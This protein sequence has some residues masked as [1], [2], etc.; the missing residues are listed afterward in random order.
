[1]MNSKEIRAEE[2]KLLAALRTD[3]PRLE[4]LWRSV[5][6]HWGGEDFVYRFYHQSFKVFALQQLTNSIVEALRSL[7]PHLP[8]NPWFTEIVAEGTGKTFTY[9]MNDRWT[10]EARPIVEAFF[11]ARYFL[12]MVCKYGKE[13]Q[14]RRIAAQR[15]GGGIGTLSPALGTGSSFLRP[16]MANQPNEH[17]CDAAKVHR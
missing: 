4:E 7:A 16:L 8:L 6:D 14:N 11:H 5:N 12:E 9:E 13:L 15:L 17:D 1:M 10:K 2:A 3:L